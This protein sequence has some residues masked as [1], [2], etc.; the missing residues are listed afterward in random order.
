MDS[1][2]NDPE[3]LHLVPPTRQK[4]QEWRAVLGSAGIPY[5]TESLGGR[6]C[7]IV[8]PRFREQVL[9]LI[10]EFEEESHVWP[11]QLEIDDGEIAASSIVSVMVAGWLIAFFVVTGPYNHAVSWFIDGRADSNLILN[12][13]YWR[14]I[15]ALTL[16]SHFGHLAGNAACCVLIGA[17]VCRYL[18]FGSGWLLILVAGA[19]GNLLTAW[20]QGPGHRSIGAST[21]VFAALG[22]LGAMR[23]MQ[24]LLPGTFGVKF[25]LLPI[26]AVI[27]LLGQLGTA[28]GADW[29]AHLFGALCGLGLGCL[30]PLIM[31]TRDW[32]AFQISCLILVIAI[33][34]L[35]WQIA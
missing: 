35:S 26:I 10:G 7:I 21:A 29:A 18:G 4:T 27:V 14:L 25:V 1:D 15:T 31:R 24:H 3:P 8:A 2:H 9:D 34:T 33:V 32:I 11:P 12:G 19:G 5:E 16:H 23:A 28:P 6:S 20:A 30:A 22:I 17:T 13:E